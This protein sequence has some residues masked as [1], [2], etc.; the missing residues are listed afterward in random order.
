MHERTRYYGYAVHQRDY[1]GVINRQSHD[2][3]QVYQRNFGDTMHRPE[4][5]LSDATRKSQLQG[6]RNNIPPRFYSNYNDADAKRSETQYG[7]PSSRF[8]HENVFC[9]IGSVRQ[10]KTKR[11]A[12][13]EDSLF[14]HGDPVPETYLGDWDQSP[15]CPRAKWTYRQENPTWQPP[16]LCR[17]GDYSGTEL[18]CL[19][20]SIF[21]SLLL[22]LIEY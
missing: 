2:N 22:L 7:Q 4:N 5:G 11:N 21:F 6:Y 1:A 15:E 16:I 19:F 8:G 14:P 17:T 13:M 10:A 20:I 12:A 3:R 18:V 9:P